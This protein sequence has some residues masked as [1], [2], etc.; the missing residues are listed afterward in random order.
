MVMT[1]MIMV[2][3]MM[4]SLLSVRALSSAQ[5]SAEESSPP[6]TTTPPYVVLITGCSS[7]I[8]KSAALEFARHPQFKVWATMRNPQKWALPA[9]LET[10]QNL[11]VIGMDVTQQD[12]V[13]AAVRQIIEEDGHLDIVINNAGYGI[14]GALELVTVD[15][16]KALFDVNVWG[17][18]RVLHAVLPH[19]RNN[20]VKGRGGQIINISSTSGV[21]GIPCFDMYTASKHALEGLSDSLRYPLSAFNISVTN[22]NAGPVRTSFTDT[23]GNAAAG[24]R[25]TRTLEND[26]TAEYLQTFTDRMVAGLNQRMHAPGAQDVEEISQLLIKLALIKI[27]TKRITDVP[28]N[29]ASNYDSQKVLEEI[30]VNP[31]GWGKIHYEILQSVPPVPNHYLAEQSAPAREEL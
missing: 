6:P 28:F 30:R 15:E 24:G 22:V 16:A 10:P 31:T 29:I 13:D 9:G 11:R 7:G 12:S 17:V 23:F 27:N 3:M 2:V 18:M 5:N 14:A 1:M 21:R 19:M 26:P 25:G 4:M 8:G 20:A